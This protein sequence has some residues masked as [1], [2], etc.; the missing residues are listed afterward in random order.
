MTIKEAKEKAMRFC[1]RKE[2]CRKEIY[3]KSV[4]WGC[5]N[6]EAHEIVDFL[7]EQK[8]VDEDR[9]TEAFVKDKLRFNKW[10]RVKIAYML[11]SQNID[12][13]IILDVF[14]GIDETEYCRILFEELKKK[15]KT[16]N[17]KPIEIRKKLFCFATGRGFESDI[18]HNTISKIVDRE[19]NE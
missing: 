13:N 10:G 1:S 3:D 7:V 6:A 17:G 19:D 9:Y 4:S 5:T 16:I 12:K 8:F 2:C 18:V 11:H 14:S 15:Y